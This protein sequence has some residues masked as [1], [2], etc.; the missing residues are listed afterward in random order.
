M[1]GGAKGFLGLIMIVI[2]VILEK[3]FVASKLFV[4]FFI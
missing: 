2:Y 3:K 1:L 4:A